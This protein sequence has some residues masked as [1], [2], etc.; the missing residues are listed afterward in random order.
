[1]NRKNLEIVKFQSKL[2]DSF[3]LNENVVPAPV[4]HL[5]S[6][7]PLPGRRG[8]A[9]WFTGPT[10]DKASVDGSGLASL[11]ATSEGAAPSACLSHVSPVTGIEMESQRRAVSPQVGQHP[12]LCSEEKIN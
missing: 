2:L 8:A 3:L 12:P 6:M 1:M 9:A 11:M 5:E 10:L 7:A 4:P